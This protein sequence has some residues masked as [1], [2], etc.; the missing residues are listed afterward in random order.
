MPLV[1]RDVRKQSWFLRFGKGALPLFVVCI[2]FSMGGY[3]H[4]PIIALSSLAAAGVVLWVGWSSICSNLV[5]KWLGVIL[6]L[7][8]GLVVGLLALGV[9]IRVSLILF[10]LLLVGV[11]VLAYDLLFRAPSAGRLERAGTEKR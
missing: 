2:L 1:E 5:T 8:I 3:N 4:G 7:Y 10:P 6:A 11:P 9:A